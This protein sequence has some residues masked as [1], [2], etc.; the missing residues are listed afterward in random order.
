MA[1]PHKNFD[2][3]HHVKSHA[4]VQLINKGLIYGE[5]ERQYA[6][7]RQ[8]RMAAQACTTP[9]SQ[10]LDPLPLPARSPNPKHGAVGV[11]LLGGPSPSGFRRPPAPPP[12]HD[13]T[14]T[15]T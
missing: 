1:E 13:F 12:A 7:S 5:L 10:A 3:A 2:F 6:E 8:V 15:R 11:T 14:S 9:K 4:L